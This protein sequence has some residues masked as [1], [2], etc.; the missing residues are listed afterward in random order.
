MLRQASKMSSAA[1][2]SHAD[3]V[4]DA[5]EASLHDSL[6]GDG[7]FLRVVRN[8]SWLAFGEGGTRLFRVAANVALARF[9]SRDGFGML[10]LAQSSATYAVLGADLGVSLYAQA[11]AARSDRQNLAQL[12]EE[13]VPVR[14]TLGVLICIAFM[15]ISATIF[16]SWSTRLTFAAAGLCI[17]AETLR[18]DWLFRGRERFDLVTL[19]RM[20]EVCALLGWVL[21]VGRRP[22]AMPLD[23]LGW[24]LSGCVLASVWLLLLSKI[25][26]RPIRMRLR[27]AK[28]FGHV[29]EA[30]FLA[31]ANALHSGIWLGPFWLI[32]WFHNSGEAGRFA[33][34]WGL[35]TSI[36]NLG[37][38][39][40]MAFFPTSASLYHESPQEFLR[41]RREL[42][43]AMLIFGL[44]IAVLGTLVAPPLVTMLFG[45]DF[46][47][48]ATVFSVLI[49]LVP[50]RY[51]RSVYGTTFVSSGMQRVQP[52]G[53][54]AGLIAALIFSVPLV[55]SH[56]ATGAATTIVIAECFNL[57]VTISLARM[58]QGAGTLPEHGRLVRV[59]AINVAIGMCGVI[60]SRRLTWVPYIVLSLICY[61]PA[62]IMLDLVKPSAI[63]AALVKT[64]T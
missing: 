19:A 27:F 25:L 15:V 54:S 47:T 12:A 34:P 48:S 21:L 62:L 52:I 28:W 33:A 31:V 14:A 53:S 40:V 29:R 11:E 37:T 9:L 6:R 61:P 26:H 58:F 18:V 51:V 4:A 32:A 57:G 42:V 41:S 1:L 20:F 35:V 45:K 56:G 63:S 49:W 22:W 30:I 38:V 43:L 59:A 44:P 5:H 60:A 36:I 8:A 13:I 3:H 10:T 7:V 23:S 55:R 24:S 16:S 39:L 64:P 17:A 46:T 50:F 2:K